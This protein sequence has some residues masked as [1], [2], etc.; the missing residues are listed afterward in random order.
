MINFS[1]EKMF[2]KR[3]NNLKSDRKLFCYPLRSKAF[4]S[5]SEFVLIQGKKWNRWSSLT[6]KV[7]HINL[8]NASNLL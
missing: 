3:S 1:S 7:D 4:K 2:V 6:W 8:C 5:M